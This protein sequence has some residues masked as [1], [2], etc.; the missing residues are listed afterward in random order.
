M[1]VRQVEH[2]CFRA[3]CWAFLDAESSLTAAEV[4][5]KSYASFAK[6][7]QAKRDF[8]TL[9]ESGTRRAALTAR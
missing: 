6:A 4:A 2:R 5:R 8:T 7:W 3:D 1:V 9:A